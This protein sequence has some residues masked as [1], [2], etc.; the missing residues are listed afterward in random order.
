MH[1]LGIAVAA[2][3]QPSVLFKVV[4][5]HFDSLAVVGIQKPFLLEEAMLAPRVF[6]ELALDVPTALVKTH[7]GKGLLILRC[8]RDFSQVDTF[9][10]VFCRPYADFLTVDKEFVFA[11]ETCNHQALLVHL[12]NEGNHILGSRL[13]TV[14]HPT[15]CNRVHGVRKRF[16]QIVEFDFVTCLLKVGNGAVFLFHN[17]HGLCIDIHI[18]NT[19][20]CKTLGFEEEVGHNHMA[21]VVGMDAVGTT[22]RKCRIFLLPFAVKF[23]HRCVHIGVFPAVLFGRVNLILH[24]AL[25]GRVFAMEVIAFDF[26]P[27]V[28]G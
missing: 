14:L 16:G 23:H 2:A 4:I 10:K 28:I 9:G 3:L 22:K 12:L 7:H 19:L 21:V 8:E 26:S 17:L 20:A 18:G 5:H 27:F 11:A 15:A 1:H 13:R 24:D 6:T 25:D